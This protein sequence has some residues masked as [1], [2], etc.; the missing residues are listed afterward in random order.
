MTAG[1]RSRDPRIREA[2]AAPAAVEVPYRAAYNGCTMR[3]M[4]FIAA[5]L[6]LSLPLPALAQQGAAAGP[7][8]AVRT[9]KPARAYLQ[10]PYRFE[11]KVDGGI[12]PVKWRVTNGS[13]PPGLALSSDG[14]LSGTPVK[15]GTFSFTVT[16]S[17]SGI[18]VQ[19]IASVLTITV[20]PPLTVRWSHIPKVNGQRVDGAI[21]VS[22]QTGEDF[23][24][25]MTV[26][27]VNEN[28]RATAIGY[29][30]FPLKKNTNDF[31]IPFGENLPF[32]AYNVNVDVIAEVAPIN[33]IFRGRL[34]TR[35]NIIQ[36][37]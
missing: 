17:D 10:S 25:T 14:L 24:L 27:A 33:S 16:L 8:L 3:S 21:K 6:L 26:L 36:A 4:Y 22:N 23:D 9:L 1:K 32:G 12:R 35:V 2:Y 19:Q 11:L 20:V 13:M 7:P 30:R 29:Q 31:E 5:A 34:M 28:G 18:P 37:P 15:A